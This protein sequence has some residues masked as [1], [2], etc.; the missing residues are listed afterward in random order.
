MKA[1]R[2]TALLALAGLQT[3]LCSA[4]SS[5]Q[6]AENYPFIAKEMSDGGGDFFWKSYQ[7]LTEDHYVLTLFRIQ[8]DKRGK[9]IH[10]QGSKGPLLF[11][12]GFVSDSLGWFTRSDE[13]RLS[14]GSQ[15]FL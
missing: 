15:L 2:I 14:V 10:G 5:A 9:K 3:K 8:G 1:M 13:E 12:H 6:D 4:R 7:T 11:Q